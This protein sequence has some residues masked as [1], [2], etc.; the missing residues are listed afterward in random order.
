MII[1]R[2]GKI[3]QAKSR[4]GGVYSGSWLIPGGGV[5][6]GESDERALAREIQEETGLDISSYKLELIDDTKTGSSE[7]S[8]RQTGERV[9]S[10]MR[11]VDYKVVL[12][13]KNADE[14]K[15][16]LSDE[17]TEYRW[18]LPSELDELKLSPPSRELFKKMGYIR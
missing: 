6:E 7:K 12:A 3:F 15:I 8:L 17:H 14:V 18:F 1:S 13:D 10:R 11:F 4:P 2:D 9:I 16:K 5:E